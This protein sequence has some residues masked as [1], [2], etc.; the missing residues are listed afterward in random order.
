MSIVQTYKKHL[1]KILVLFGILS[2]Q[3]PMNPKFPKHL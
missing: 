3:I 1:F 2:I